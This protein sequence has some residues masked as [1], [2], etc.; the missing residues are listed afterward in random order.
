MRAAVEVIPPEG[1]SLVEGSG[2]HLGLNTNQ[3][4]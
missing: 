1:K 4:S 3:I 2:S